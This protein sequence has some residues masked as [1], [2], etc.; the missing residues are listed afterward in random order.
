MPSSIYA[1]SLE[2]KTLTNLP[3]ESYII[4]A[5]AFV[6]GVIFTWLIASSSKKSSMKDFSDTLE[7]EKKRTTETKQR[8]AST[9]KDLQIL[10]D[11]EATL[12]QNEINVNSTIKANQ[13]ITPM[14]EKLEKVE[15]RI[16]ELEKTR[17]TDHASLKLQVQQIMENQ[18]GYQQET[19]Q[20]LSS[21]NQS[22]AGFAQPSFIN[23]INTDPQLEKPLSIPAEKTKPIDTIVADE[24][25]NDFSDSLAD[26]FEGF[27]AESP[28]D[29][30]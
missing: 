4:T 27:T 17:A 5:V 23:D 13:L 20:L 10:R 18:K 1:V 8:L 29:G 2:L 19:T 25:S 7:I 14:A 16:T 11:S 30:I 15:Q 9:Q 22:E 28:G 24:D 12:K 26:D 6:I 3:V 21:L